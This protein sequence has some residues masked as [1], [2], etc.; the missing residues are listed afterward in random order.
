[1]TRRRSLSAPFGE[2]DRRVRPD[3]RLVSRGLVVDAAPQQR[4]KQALRAAERLSRAVVEGLEEGVLVLDAGLAPVSWNASVLRILGVSAQELADTARLAATHPVETLRYDTGKP[5]T[6]QDNPAVRALRQ[7]APV[8]ATLRR[9]TATG[10]ERWITV[11]A[12]PL[13]GAL[14][15][16]RRG[17]VC[18]FADVTWSVES[19]RRLR[20]ER[21]RAQRYLDV[22]STI[23]VVLDPAGRIELVNGQGCEL[24][25]YAE[26]ELVGRDWF[27]TVV[28]PGDRRDGRAGFRQLLADGELPP[29]RAE[30]FVLTKSGE[31]R[32]IEVTAPPPGR[33]PRSCARART[34]PSAAAPRPSS[35]TSPITTA[36]PACPTARCWRSSCTATSRAPAA[37]TAA[38]RSC[39]SVST[40]SS[41]STTRSATPPATRCCAPSA[42]ACRS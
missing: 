13:G 23:V 38:S 7:G 26:Q 3:G 11:L 31:E 29:E 1:M 41:S 42:S 32:R 27:E 18:T 2:R 30:T 6:Q 12:R 20:E 24:L 14:G 9:T 22:A 34:S 8:R 37:P 21:D 17:V 25:G 33:S 36:S 10:G 15:T 4:A 28:P 39:S 16:Q 40:T 5:L 19:E 35:P